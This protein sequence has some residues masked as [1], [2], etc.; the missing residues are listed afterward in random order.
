MED[1]DSHAF[2]WRN[3][4]NASY[5]LADIVQCAKSLFVEMGDQADL[6]EAVDRI[7]DDLDRKLAELEQS[8]VAN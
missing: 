6:R 4:V 2:S 8:S 7:S 3:W 5:A 1:T